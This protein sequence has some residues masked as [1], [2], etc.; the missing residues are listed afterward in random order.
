MRLRNGHH[1]HGAW[2]AGAFCRANVLPRAAWRR[3]RTRTRRLSGTVLRILRGAW[4]RGRPA[5]ARLTWRGLVGRRL[6]ATVGNARGARQ[7]PEIS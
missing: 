3:G 1:R 5:C 4:M 2:K 6:A 7:R